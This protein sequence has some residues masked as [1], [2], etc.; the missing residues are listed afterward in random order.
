MKYKNNLQFSLYNNYSEKE[1]AELTVKIVAL[2][3]IKSNEY[4]T[5]NW[6][7]W[8]KRVSMVR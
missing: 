8:F 3:S 6:Y 1:I 7:S 2:K 4:Y 5:N